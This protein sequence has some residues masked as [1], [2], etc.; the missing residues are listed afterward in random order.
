MFL[1]L[2]VS[3]AFWVGF[4]LHRT[5]SI[6]Q[7]QPYPDDKVFD[8]TKESRP[9][10]L[11]SRSIS[12]KGLWS[13]ALGCTHNLVHPLGEE[14][15]RKEIIQSAEEGVG[16]ACKIEVTDTCHSY[17]YFFVGKKGSKPLVGYQLVGIIQK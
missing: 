10:A 13:D 5:V 11:T 1:S 3:D 4:V 16:R 8:L 17:V 7:L 9:C 12:D 2:A 6:V 14:T 15:S